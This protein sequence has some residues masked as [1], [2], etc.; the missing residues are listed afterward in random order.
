MFNTAIFYS[1]VDLFR[2]DTIKLDVTFTRTAVP[3]EETTY[4][5]QKYEIPSDK[6]YHLIATKPIIDNA[7]VMHHTILYGCPA[8]VDLSE[9]Y[10]FISVFSVLMKVVWPHFQ[11][12]VSPVRVKEISKLVRCEGLLNCPL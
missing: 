8:E 5:C 11:K 9:F 3:A 7:Y 12:T 1:I 2:V 4:I 10:Q 6:M